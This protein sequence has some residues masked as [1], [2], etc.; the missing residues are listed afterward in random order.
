[1]ENPDIHDCGKLR[2]VLQFLNQ[3]IGDD[4]AIGDENIYEV[5]TYVDMSYGTYDNM[6]GHTGGSVIFYWWLIHE[7]P[8]K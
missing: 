7:K 4:H 1:M 8:P 5:L 2:Q 3:T 6:R